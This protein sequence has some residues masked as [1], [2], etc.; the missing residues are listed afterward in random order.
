MQTLTTNPPQAR[1]RKLDFAGLSTVSLEGEHFLRV[2]SELLRQLTEEAFADVSHLL[3]TSHL[4]QL[5]AILE[6]PDASD[7][8]RYVALELLKNAVISA[9]REFPSCQDTGTAI[10]AGKKGQNVLV[11]GDARAAVE[12]GIA[13][14]WSKRNLRFSQMAP[15]DMFTEQ[16]TGTNLP[17]Q[18][19]IEAVSGD[20]MELLFMAKGGGSANK[21]F[22]FQETRRL[23]E[24]ERLR[25][26]FDE[27]IR[28]LGTTACPPY[29]L[30]FVIGG[31]SAEHCLKTVKMAS[32][33]MLDDLPTSGSP[34]G[35]AFRDLDAEEMILALTRDLGLGAQF[36][37]KYFCHDVRV[38][39]LPRHGGS[40]PVGMGVSCS[41]DR[42]I[43]ARIDREGAWLEELERD[44]ARF[45]PEGEFASAAA[46]HI[47]LDQPMGA[48]CAALSDIPVS[49][50]VLLSGTMIVARDLVHAELARRIADGKQLPDYV[51]NHPV[52]YAGPAK[53]PEGHASG[54]FGPTTA[55][56]MDP[57]VADLQARGASRVMIA[58]G[59]RSRQV[60]DSCK[61][62]GGFY[63]GSV[64]GAAAVLGRD[65]IKQIEVID[66]PEFG[67][68]AVHRIRVE[69]F[70]AFVIIDDKGGDFFTRR[71]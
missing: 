9:E 61:A 41:A 7:N 4:A 46:V 60:I 16:N 21:T 26:F 17:A 70:P 3:R 43:R 23:L 13:R 54:S 36:G 47:D 42:Q 44:P 62:N 14:T 30:A 69:N 32:A 57:Y 56:R 55:T 11:S 18:I 22:L 38:I 10:V 35:R 8:D 40:L 53:T 65:V 20:T 37:G 45:L 31:L 67:M 24:P 29:H 5:R 27:K 39:R 71:P 19:D 63:L 25:A 34:D 50:P 6:D 66:F 33:R 52:Y 59:N 49:S 64:G 48:I 58:K 12:Q 28:T 51:L 15:L 2:S 68:E 1:Y